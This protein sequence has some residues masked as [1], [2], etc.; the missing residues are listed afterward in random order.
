LSLTYPSSKGAIFYKGAL[1]NSF[2]SFGSAGYCN[3]LP[4]PIT[5]GQG[6]IRE[7]LL[8][9]QNSTALSYDIAG[10]DILREVRC[11]D[12]I[13]CRQSLLT[14]YVTTVGCF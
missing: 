6:H 5:G 2:D 4:G 14:P 11:I 12:P 10:L 1:F 8:G 9:P 7:S 3:K 13:D